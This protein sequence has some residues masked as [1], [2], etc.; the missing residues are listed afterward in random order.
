MYTNLR[1]EAS[2]NQVPFTFPTV[3]HRCQLIQNLR[4]PNEKAEPRQARWQYQRARPPYRNPFL[5]SSAGVMEGGQ[6]MAA[7]GG[8]QDTRDAKP[9]PEMF[10]P[11]VCSSGPVRPSQTT[12]SLTKRF[13]IANLSDADVFAQISSLLVVAAVLGRQGCNDFQARPGEQCLSHPPATPNTTSPSCLL[14]QIATTAGC[15]LPYP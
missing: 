5:S 2:P 12:T 10:L 6:V 1:S 15:P 9:L 7:V 8:L 13:G 14:K 3:T 11:E 4:I